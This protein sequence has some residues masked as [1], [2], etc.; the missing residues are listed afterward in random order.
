MHVVNTISQLIN[1]ASQSD[2]GVSSK[3]ESCTRDVEM[4]NGFELGG[5]TVVLIDTP[6]SDDSERSNVDV[7]QNITA[8]L[9]AQ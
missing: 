5:K 4:T 8:F 3:L 2:L 6:G 1:L 7:F 9:E